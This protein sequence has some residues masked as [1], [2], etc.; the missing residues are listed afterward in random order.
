MATSLNIK[1]D[2]S[3]ELIDQSILPTYTGSALSTVTIFTGTPVGPLG[4]HTYGIFFTA[5]VINTLVYL[6]SSGR[7][8]KEKRWRLKSDE[9][10]KG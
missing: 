6:C 10:C 9:A 7:E 3:I 8:M 4:M 2:E 5:L 1:L